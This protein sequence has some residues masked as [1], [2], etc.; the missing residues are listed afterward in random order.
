MVS[1]SAPVANSPTTVKVY[2]IGFKDYRGKYSKDS[3]C[4]ILRV[5]SAM[6]CTEIISNVKLWIL[7]K[8]VEPKHNLVAPTMWFIADEKL[9]DRMSSGYNQ[10]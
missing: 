4:S 7:A 2:V 9:H 3:K 8:V 10:T 6:Q 5:V 1:V